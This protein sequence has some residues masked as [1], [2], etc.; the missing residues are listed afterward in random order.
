MTIENRQLLNSAG[1]DGKVTKIYCVGLFRTGTNT[2]FEV[3]NRSYRAGHEFMLEQTLMSVHGYVS[4]QIS[5]DEF[6]EFVRNR[7][8]EG[9]LEL[10]SYGFTYFFIDILVKEFPDAKFILTIRDCYS[11]VNSCIANVH[12]YYEEESIQGLLSLFS[13][14][15]HL[16]DNRFE[17]IDRSGNKVCLEQ[18]IKIWNQVNTNILNTV[19][20]DRLL[21]LK[22]GDLADSLPELAHFVGASVDDLDILHANKGDSI[23]YLSCFEPVALEKI[24]DQHCRKLMSDIFPEITF[25]TY[26]KDGALEKI[27]DPSDVGKIFSLQWEQADA[28]ETLAADAS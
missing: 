10:D 21:I 5:R 20:A 7:D 24:F 14:I 12:R 8:V 28:P 26:M 22:T 1:K 13:N 18:M 16:P 15:D 3:F 27:I 11:W 25:A 6:I 2:I 19:P 17:W 9:N 23:N 4:G